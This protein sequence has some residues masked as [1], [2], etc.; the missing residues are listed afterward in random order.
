MTDDPY[1][2]RSGASREGIRS[3]RDS[4]P[5]ACK[6]AVPYKSWTR[7]PGLEKLQGAKTFYAQQQ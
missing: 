6:G 2:N 1:H 7:S 4:R 5:Q 3:M